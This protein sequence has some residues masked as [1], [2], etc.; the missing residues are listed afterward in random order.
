MIDIRLRKGVSGGDE[1]V[2]YIENVKED[3]LENLLEKEFP[4][5]VN[6]LNV[7]LRKM[8]FEVCSK[9][10]SKIENKEKLQNPMEFKG[11]DVEFRDK[12]NVS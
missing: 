6:K 12:E 9:S 8:G 1:F 10:G 7:E 2:H 5:I 3:Q 4:I 11:K